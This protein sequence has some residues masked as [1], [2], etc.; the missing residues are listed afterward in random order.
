MASL[1]NFVRNKLRTIFNLPG[2]EKYV[3]NIEKSLFNYSL[4]RCKGGMSWK[5]A[6]L[7]SLYKQR[8]INL[9]YNINHPGNPTIRADI[10]NNVI[11]TPDLAEFGPDKLWPGGLYAQGLAAFRESEQEK[12][13]RIRRAKEE[14]E[15]DDRNGAHMC[16]KCK[17]WKTSYY[18]LQTRSADEPMTTFVT[19][20][21][22]EKRWKF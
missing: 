3:V 10:R 14:E 17:S 6:R 9:W 19:C 2:E 8:W 12:E 1:R 20:H 4:K 13:A 7:R 21:A 22:C 11:K 15:S 5:N 18:Q 16:G